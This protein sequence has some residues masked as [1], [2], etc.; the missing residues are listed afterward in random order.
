MKRIL[1]MLAAVTA[2]AALTVPAASAGNW[3]DAGLDAA[4]SSVAGHP[5]QVWCESSWGDWIHAGDAFSVDFDLV[6]GYTDPTASTM[7]YI[8]PGLCETLHALLVFGPAKVGNYWG[9]LAVHA[10]VHESEHQAGHVDE[11]ETDCAALA[12]DDSAAVQFFGYQT[13]EQ[14]P[15]TV[16]VRHKTKRTVT[17]T[18]QVRYRTAPSKQLA[19]FHAFDHAWH[20]S[21]PAAYQGGCT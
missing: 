5:V 3:P 2:I 20:A 1:V 19:E 4:A 10:L 21:A 13:S 6:L 12:V 18:R 7:I 15:Y 14:Q 9:S 16:T 17:V 8:S 11:G